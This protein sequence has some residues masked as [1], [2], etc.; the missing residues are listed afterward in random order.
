MS[1]SGAVVLIY[2]HVPASPARKHTDHMPPAPLASA[3]AENSAASAAAAATAAAT[4]ATAASISKRRRENSTESQAPPASSAQETAVEDERRSKNLLDAVRRSYREELNPKIHDLDRGIFYN[5]CETAA[6]MME[7][8]ARN[9]LIKSQIKNPLEAREIARASLEAKIEALPH[10]IMKAVLHTVL[11]FS[12]QS[13]SSISAQASV[14]AEEASAEKKPPAVLLRTIIVDVLNGR[15]EEENLNGNSE[16]EQ[17][18][19]LPPRE[20][21]RFV[22]K[23]TG[24]LI[25][26]T[27]F[28]FAEW[29]VVE[30]KVC[31][32]N[33]LRLAIVMLELH[34]VFK[35][36]SAEDA[37]EAMD[38]KT[39]MAKEK[40]EANLALLFQG[41]AKAAEANLQ[42]LH[43]ELGELE[44]S[45]GCSDAQ[46]AMEEAKNR[47]DEY[48]TTFAQTLEAM[49]SLAQGC[50]NNNN[51]RKR[52]RLEEDDKVESSQDGAEEEEF[53]N[54]MQKVREEHILVCE[55][56][57][58]QLTKAYEAKAQEYSALQQSNA[59]LMR[60]IQKIRAEIALRERPSAS[61]EGGGLLQP[62]KAHVAAK[63][64]A[65]VESILKKVR[66]Y[67][68]GNIKDY[69]CL[70]GSDNK[71]VLRDC[72]KFLKGVVSDEKVLMD[73]RMSFFMATS[74]YF[75]SINEKHD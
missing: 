41:E 72:I 49:A 51:S 58:V 64:N 56:R 35:F 59:D 27:G 38:H 28:D 44:K 54:Q 24:A 63:V 47:L 68:Q 73:A 45:S 55:R 50:N 66:Q 65:G 33:C 10:P 37:E 25:L 71:R 22:S 40:A 48:C 62:H 52:R 43:A 18:A 14:V 36:K 5:F 67:Y 16:E 12:Q 69:L 32:F 30:D 19:G 42:A 13:I 61:G 1:I 74:A 9:A 15:C 17:K 29:N 46:M 8:R 4:A 7:K 11:K 70:I 34:P 75:N 20:N 60:K 3:A 53:M 39:K 23:E 2:R 6:A 26:E 21:I 31:Y 57:K